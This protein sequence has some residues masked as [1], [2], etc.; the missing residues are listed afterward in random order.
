ML[1]GVFMSPIRALTASALCSRKFCRY[2]ISQ[3]EE[4]GKKKD[5]IS[6]RCWD[7]DRRVGKKGEFWYGLC[8]HD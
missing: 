1:I 4:R 2:I 7:L 6:S 3:K 5:Y 8:M